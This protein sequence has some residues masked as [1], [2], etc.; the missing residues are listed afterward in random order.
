MGNTLKLSNNCRNHLND[1]NPDKTKKPL[2]SMETVET[3]EPLEIMENSGTM[4]NPSN[5]VKLWKL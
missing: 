5:Y 4:K 1:G 3:M 2:K